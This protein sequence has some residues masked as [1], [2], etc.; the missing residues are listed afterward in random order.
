MLMTV[1]CPLPPFI[2]L[3]VIIPGYYTDQVVRVSRSSAAQEEEEQ[4]Q[5]DQEETDQDMDIEPVPKAKNKPRKKKPVPVGRNGLKKKRLVKSRQ[6][7]DAK[8][9][10]GVLLVLC[11]HRL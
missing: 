3:Q 4:E 5:E 6:T 8:G 9:Y 2:W 1:G 11:I 7:T 10:F